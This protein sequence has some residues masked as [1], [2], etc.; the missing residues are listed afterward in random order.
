MVL[1]T[2]QSVAT[3]RSV[4][5]YR[6]VGRSFYR[7]VGRRFYRPVGRW[8]TGTPFLRKFLRKFSRAI[9]ALQNL[10]LFSDRRASGVGQNLAL[11]SERR[12]SGVGQNLG[13][14][15]RR[16]S[17]GSSQQSFAVFTGCLPTESQPIL[18]S[19]G[20]PPRPESLQRIAMLR[21]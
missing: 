17:A 9:K 15:L 10:A 7:P 18:R 11:F 2:G 5:G 16:R 19:T 21:A 12:V 13:S 20:A 6:P 1:P 4:S 8:C 14:F 3:D